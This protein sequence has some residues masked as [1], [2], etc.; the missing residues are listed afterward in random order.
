MM[1]TPAARGPE[2]PCISRQQRAVALLCAAVACSL[3]VGSMMGIAAMY[4]G[5]ADAVIAAVQGQ[6]AETKVAAVVVPA[7]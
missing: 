6:A 5:E 1:K 4:T 7:R 2:L 3:V